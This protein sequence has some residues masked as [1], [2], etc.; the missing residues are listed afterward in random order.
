MAKNK[1]ITTAERERIIDLLRN[2]TSVNA[3]AKQTGRS[4]SAV[5]KIGKEAGIDSLSRAHSRL[6]RAHT[7]RIAY[8]VEARAERLV[9]MH[10]AMDRIIDRM[11]E[12]TVVFHFGGKDN[13]LAEKELDE[14][15]S[16]TLTEYSRAVAALSQAEATVLRHDERG[17][18]VTSAFDEW[19]AEKSGQAQEHTA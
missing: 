12:R 16:R 5:S 19:L 6:A 17:D 15:D 1:P 14:P 3:T 13:T 18:E 8:G 4:A 9:K 10:A 2:G 7:A 11:G